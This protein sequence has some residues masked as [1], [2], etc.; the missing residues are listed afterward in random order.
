MDTQ[1]NAL[2]TLAVLARTVFWLLELR[3][4]Q[5]FSTF[6]RPSVQA[7]DAQVT[8]QRFG[9]WETVGRRGRAGQEALP[10]PPQQI[11]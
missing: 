11:R 1:L 10:E 4:S 6:Y 5:H 7:V 8:R 3:V 2:P 9:D